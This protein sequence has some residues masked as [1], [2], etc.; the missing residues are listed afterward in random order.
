MVIMFYILPETEGRSLEDVEL[1][2]SDNS[3]N[4]TDINI[5]IMSRHK[6]E[7][8]EILPLNQ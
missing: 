3:R 2:F 8:S 1:H 4:W 6:A 7:P 5:Q